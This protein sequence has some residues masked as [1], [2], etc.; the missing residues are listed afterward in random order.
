MNLPG[1]LLASKISY[2][3]TPA[4]LPSGKWYIKNMDTENDQH[5]VY[6]TGIIHDKTNI[7]AILY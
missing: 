4:L 6:I 3:Q 1:H 7:K 2:L 5:G